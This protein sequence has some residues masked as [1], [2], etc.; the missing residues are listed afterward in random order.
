MISGWDKLCMRLIYDSLY[1]FLCRN[2]VLL[3]YF[4]IQKFVEKN[5][6]LVPSAQQEHIPTNDWLL[7]ILSYRFKYVMS[8]SVCVQI[9]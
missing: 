3:Q 5:G 9:V 8:I 7:Q 6:S 1:I 4:F 2:P